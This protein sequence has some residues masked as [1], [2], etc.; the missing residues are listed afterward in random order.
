[1]LQ[2]SNI[3]SGSRRISL[4]ISLG[5]I[6]KRVSS[7]TVGQ[8][9]QQQLSSSNVAFGQLGGLCWGG[10]WFTRGESQFIVWPEGAAG[11]PGRV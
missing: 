7:Q 5:S 2:I 3:V 9:Q 8:L 11:R 6:C 1:M 10:R 4:E